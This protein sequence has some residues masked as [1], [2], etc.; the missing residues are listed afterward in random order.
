MA[1][2]ISSTSYVRQRIEELRESKKLAR[3]VEIAL[4]E[5]KAEDAAE[6]KRKSDARIAAKLARIAGEEPPVIEEPAVEAV[7]AEEVQEELVIEEEPIIKKAA[8]K[9][10]VKKETEESEED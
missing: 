5:K 4:A 7:A 6:K 9:A 2:L 1:D 3:Q 10:A 8:K